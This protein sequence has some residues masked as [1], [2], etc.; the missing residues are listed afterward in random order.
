MRAHVAREAPREACG[1][2]V[3]EGEEARDVWPMPNVAP[4]PHIRYL[5]DPHALVRAFQRMDEQGWEL[6]AI[7]HSHPGGMAYPSAIDV[8][9]AA[10]PV[11]YVI[12]APVGRE[13]FCRGYRLDDGRILPVPLRLR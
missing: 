1:L 10:Y 2:I 4:Q 3:G 9:Q 13:W 7:Y 8:A 12:W 5:V 11:V 6:L